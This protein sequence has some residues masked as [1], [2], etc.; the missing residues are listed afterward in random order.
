MENSTAGTEARHLSKKENFVNQAMGFLASRRAIPLRLLL[1]CLWLAALA[2]GGMAQGKIGTVSQ[3]DQAVFLPKT[4][5]ST[6]ATNAAKDFND[7]AIIPALIVATTTDGAEL[8]EA[9]MTW[10]RDLAASLP[11]AEIPGDMK[12]SELIDGDADFVPAVTKP[13]RPG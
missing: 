7:S 1:L 10:L 4:A 11:D 5:E 12:F 2:F 6:L 3:N 9:Q 13:F 8:S